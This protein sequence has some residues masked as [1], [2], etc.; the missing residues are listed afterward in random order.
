[1]TEYEEFLMRKV[2]EAVKCGARIEDSDI[3][4]ILFPHQRDIVRWAVI[5]GRRAIFASFGLGKTVMQLE[6]LRLVQKVHGG[7]A[8]IVC[9][10][11][12][13]QEFRKDAVML[14]IS[15][16]YVR[17][18]AEV[19]ASTANILLT[20]YERVRDGQ[21]TPSQFKAVSL[22][23]ASVLRGYG[24]KTYQE[25]LTLFPS[26]PYKYVCTATPSPNRYKE[27]IHYAG[28]LGVM[29]T[30]EAL[31]RFFQRDPE[32]AGNLT[33]YL[34]KEREFW[35]WMT[36]W[37]VFLTK[38]SDLGYSDEGYDL[39]ELEV[40]YHKVNPE[41]KSFEDLFDWN[42]SMGLEASAKE[43]R[44][45]LSVRVA[46]A[47]EIVAAHPGKHFLLWHDLEDERHAL[48]KAIPGTKAAYG[49][50]DLDDR[51]QLIVDFAD[52]KILHLATKPKISGSGC[53]FQRHCHNMIFVGIGYKFNDFIQSLHRVQRYGQTEK[54][55]AHV[56]YSE[57]EAH[58]L[59]VL[60]EKWEN[61]RKLVANM[62]DIIKE[63]GLAKEA[64]STE[65][66]RSMGLARQEIQG[67]R[68]VAVNN[69]CILETARMPE[70][71]VDLIHTSIPFG[72]HYEYSPSYN[73]LGH[74]TG[75]ETFFEQ[76][77]FLTPELLRILKPGRVAAVHVKD[78]IL[79]G[80]VTGYGMPSV[81]PFHALT[82]AHYMKHGFIFFGMIT[83]E[84][85][86]VRENNQT[87][88]L[89]WTEQCKD[90]SKMGVGCP[91]YLLL[92]RKLPSDNSKAYADLPVSK[93]KDVY[94]RGRWQIDARGKW[95]S[96]GDR[97]MSSEEI[98]VADLKHI[99]R[100]FKAWMDNTIY[101][102]ETHATLADELDKLGKLP[103]T[104][105]ALQVPARDQERV[106]SDIS[107]MRV[108]NS[109][110][111]R[112]KLQNHV[113]P[114][115]FDIVDRVITRY[116]NP[117]EVVFDPFGGIMTVPYRAVKLG[118]VGYGCELNPSYWA[119][120]TE[121]L[122]AA[123]RGAE[124]PTLS[125]FE[126]AIFDGLEADSEGDAGD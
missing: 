77:D 86:V 30:G 62:T 10:L 43:K 24:T 67:K 110:Q 56:I 47:A 2:P 50:Q 59:S 18:D 85:D 61:H 7:K 98:A 66:S 112:K 101:N 75:N 6:T 95:N 55:V 103:S 32:K 104:F 31:T 68:F 60:L 23:E 122:K 45:T 82:I 117:G 4:P 72:N 46:K 63:F 120:G 13:R 11:G 125:M 91:E 33:L 79:F 70:N 14:G 73:D 89:G 111:K 106:W 5:G 92:F 28:F 9:P 108:L 123:D 42:P 71:S 116:S 81:D 35:L 53:N 3:N 83:I 118:R 21:I 29:D 94:T 27:L 1:M 20:N 54:V 40:V 44:R 121:Y 65:L 22:D 97:F 87:Y 64:I 25:F 88:R 115:Q 49:S 76:M 36:T 105:E 51:E 114:L 52:G 119:D 80:N 78:R 37:A 26:V 58:I 84:T 15:T 113:C 16:E 57:S 126:D 39:P 8:L 96:S 102:Y 12:V 109:E 38:P 90:G 99:S 48:C 41:M 124:V 19:E 74:N 107:R 100:K 17:T 93:T 69:D 34:H